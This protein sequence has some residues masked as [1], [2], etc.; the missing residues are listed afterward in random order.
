M[1]NDFDIAVVGG[2]LA[3]LTAS[4]A[5]AK[6]GFGVALIAPEAQTA[7]RRTTALLASS[8]DFLKSLE[9]WEAIAQGSAPLKTIRI[10]DATG[11][12][13]RAPDLAFHASEIGLDAFGCNI[14]NLDLLSALKAACKATGR[15]DFIKGEVEN[16]LFGEMSQTL[17]LKGGGELACVL[18][19]GADGRNSSIRRLAELGERQWSYPQTALVLDFTHR[20][21]HDDASTEFHTAEG[22]FTFVP[23]A[24]RRCGLVWVMDPQKAE[25]R[26]ALPKALLEQEIEQQMHSVL[27]ALSI[28]SDIQAWPMSGLCAR[29]FGK[30]GVMLVGEAGH[31]FPPIGAQGFN[32]GIR[33]VELAA[34]LAKSVIAGQL[35]E[36]GPRYSHQ[37]SLDIHTRTMSVDLLNRSLLSSFLPV[38]LARLAGLNALAL[39]GPL[40]RLA[41]REGVAPGWQWKRISQ[42]FAAR[43]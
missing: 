38:Q 1:P 31:A 34:S 5:L 28:D 42:R 40:R 23:L 13:L 9:V 33:D 27:G 14:A 19:I 36:L 43:R 21:A 4:L 15:V 16:A 41:M 32:L 37:R 20:L 22:P 24:P 3:G 29:H 18:V 26:K 11:R 17:K 25:A 7:D 10:I 35:A 2:G 12:L 6:A 30:P 8:V 39:I